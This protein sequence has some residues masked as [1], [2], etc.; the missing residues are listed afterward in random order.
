MTTRALCA[1]ATF[2]LASLAIGAAPARAELAID[3]FGGVSWSKSSGLHFL[4][5]L[6]THHVAGGLS[7][8][9]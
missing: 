1:I 2:M 9:F 4:A 5:D 3:I 7:I 6:N 8:R